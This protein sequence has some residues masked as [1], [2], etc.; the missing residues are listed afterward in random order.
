M[1]EQVE[2]PDL[3]PLF[4][5]KS[6]AV[7]GA[8][9]DPGKISGLPLKNLLELGYKGKIFPVNPKREEVQGIKAF[10]SILDIPEEVD[11]AIIVI[12]A[13]FVADATR[14]CVEKGVKAAVI[15]VA[16][17]AELNE[18]GKKRQDE[19]T[20][21]ARESGIR[22]LGPNTNGMVNAI[23]R[24]PLGYSYAQE[25][26]IPGRLGYVSQSGALLS[27]TVP[28]FVNRGVGL[29]Y[30]V[31]SGNQA[32]LENFDYVRYLLDDPNTDVIAVYS[33]GVK[34]PNKFLAVADLAIEKEKPI[35]M[36]KIGRSE[37]SAKTAVAHTASLVGSDSAFDAV[38]KQKGIV[39]VYDFD[40]LVATS[41]VFLKCAI[42][43]GDR[44]GVV[45]TSGGAMGLLA[46]H[47]AEFGITN[48]PEP[49]AKTK[50][51]LLEIMT[52]YEDIKNPLDMGNA[53]SGPAL[54]S[55]LSKATPDLGGRCGT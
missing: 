14:Q 4:R 13:A 21:I 54:L 23:E 35:V 8:S 31:G 9:N 51:A 33:E 37:L 30:F 45:S 6:V 46:D 17:F 24:I 15:L 32:G 49:S 52:D 36:L 26:V 43:K 39:R 1:T 29:S 38:C 40:E 18:E 25:V 5:P 11:V 44:I 41:S 53:A 19:L 2:F 34:D 22:I 47:T 3:E 7:I 55:S 16:S 50:K 12:P 28:R 48:F 27:A 10:P 20:K 42:P